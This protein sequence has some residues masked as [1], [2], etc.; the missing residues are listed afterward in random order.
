MEQFA[1]FGNSH[2]EDHIYFCETISSGGSRISGKGGHMYKG[3]G[4][5]FADFLSFFSNNP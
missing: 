5:R 1:Q 4:V 3:I 2:Y